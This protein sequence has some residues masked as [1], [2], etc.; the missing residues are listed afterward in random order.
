MTKSRS[1]LGGIVLLMILAVL[2]LAAPAGKASAAG[3]NGAYAN[4]IDNGNFEA[5]Y[6]SWGVNGTTPE[7]TEEDSGNHVGKVVG[8]GWV[9]ARIWNASFMYDQLYKISF[10]LKLVSDNEEAE[11]ST[12]QYV[13]RIKANDG[14]FLQDSYVDI[15]CNSEDGIALNVWQTFVYFLKVSDNRDGTYEVLAGRDPAAMAALGTG[16]GEL[17]YCDIAVGS[18][19]FGNLSEWYI[20]DYV[21]TPYTEYALNLVPNGDFE[22]DYDASAPGGWGFGVQ[23]ARVETEG[24]NHVGKIEV[25]GG[26]WTGP[27]IWN[28]AFMYGKTYRISFNMKLVAGNGAEVLSGGQFLAA[29]S[30]NDNAHIPDTTYID[31]GANAGS[32]IGKWQT[33]AYYIRIEKG[34]ERDVLYTGNTADSLTKKMDCL[35]T[36]L[37]HFNPYVGCGA[38]GNVTEVY[39]DD[40]QIVEADGNLVEN[41]GMTDVFVSEGQAT[42]WGVNSYASVS[43]GRYWDAEKNSYVVRNEGGG[44]LSARL[45]A[46]DI[47]FGKLYRMSAEIRMDSDSSAALPSNMHFQFKLSDQESAVYTADIGMSQGSLSTNAYHTAVAYFRLDR[48]DDGSI[49]LS[50]GRTKETVAPTSVTFA[51]GAAFSHIDCQIGPGHEG[52]W[53]IDNVAIFDVSPLKY[54]A[55]VV[56]FDA[57]E[58]PLT[59]FTYEISGAYE[60]AVL[61]D[62]VLRIIGAEDELSVSIRKEGFVGQTVS[63]TP[64]S[65]AQRLFLL[66]AEQSYTAVLTVL[67]R[68]GNPVTD[69]SFSIGGTGSYETASAEQNVITIEKVLGE[70]TVSLK[71]SLY[72]D[73]TVTV[74]ESTAAQ[75]VTFDRRQTVPDP[76]DYTGELYAYQSFEK[77]PVSDP[78]QLMD[79]FGLSTFI[80]GGSEASIAI[81]DQESHYGD[82]A[83]LVR[84]VGDRLV[85]RMSRVQGSTNFEL[86][87]T[88]HAEFWLK[89][90][91][92]GLQIRPC[93]YLTYFVEGDVLT[94][95]ALQSIDEL[96]QLGDAVTLSTDEWTKVEV[97]FSLSVTDGKLVISS[98]YFDETRIV[99]SSVAGKGIVDVGWFDLSLN[100]RG[101]YYLDDVTFFHTYTAQVEVFNADNE[102]VTDGVI[103]TAT[104]FAGQPL[105]L[106][107]EIREGKFIV[108]GAYGVVH[109]SAQV[110][111][112]V[113]SA[114][115][116]AANTSITMASPYT[117]TVAVLDGGGETV[118]A[119][120]IHDIY[121]TFGA[122]RVEGV[123]NDALRAYTF[124]G[125][126]G[127]LKVFVYAQGF[128][129]HEFLTLTRTEPQGE[130][131][132][133]KVPSAADGLRG[134][135]AIN[136]DVE[137]LSQLEM[138]NNREYAY[139]EVQS[140]GASDRWASFQPI[141]TLSEESAVGESSMRISADSAQLAADDADYAAFME[142]NGLSNRT[143]GDRVSY[144]AGNSYLL[145]GTTYCFTVYAKAPA[146]QAADTRFTLIFL[147]VV[148]LCN[149]GQFNFWVP[150]DV[151]VTN[152]YWSKIEIWFSFELSDDEAAVAAGQY[153]FTRSKLTSCV[154]ACL[155]GELLYDRIGIYDYNVYK[156]GTYAF[157]SPGTSGEMEGWGT[158]DTAGHDGIEGQEGGRS[159]GS[160]ALLEPSFQ[161]LSANSLLIDGGTI[162]SEYEG[163]ISVLNRDL[164]ANDSVAYLRLTDQYTGEVIYLDASAYYSQVNQKYYIPDLYHGY[165]VCVCDA[166]KNPI[167]DLSE[168]TISSEVPATVIEFD[169]DMVLTIKDQ[170]GDLVTDVIVRIL[171]ANGSY[172]QATNN[173]DGTYSYS[174]L[175]GVRQISFRKE[176]G[177]EN[178][179]TFPSGITVSSAQ[180][181]FEVVVTLR[182]EDPDPG[183]DPTPGHERRSCETFAGANGGLFAFAVL[184]VCGLAALKK[185]KD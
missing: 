100:A 107:P 8:A 56:V 117:A 70:I 105:N 118:S 86:D 153:E 146:T 125:C 12:A 129:Q 60:N 109:F 20:D 115:T 38:P 180:S 34:E 170:H 102:R 62:N 163:D 96:I 99:E 49:V 155:N 16:V 164:S 18:G 104:D 167:A 65:A 157:Y 116:S 40:Y 124:E 172:A 92:E 123:W 79:S 50:Y 91:T 85:F 121:A 90:I 174:G 184:S 55:E 150:V 24:G 178:S 35:G 73:V 173:G 132:L 69:F 81:T 46:N 112:L 71:K 78:V 176:S 51:D 110:G 28:A 72:T 177:S 108:E 3:K 80:N 7:R 32:A 138:Y 29:L 161:I 93:V 95:G 25:T 141:L 31:I 27:R 48:T 162:T 169:Y 182:S 89:G 37:S 103:L 101:D 133:K 36:D 42:N 152:D 139:P 130:F 127:D 47:E 66:S 1:V 166:D 131:R 134:N 53:Y 137:S 59:G 82:H 88:Y 136:G 14:A 145:D 185:K 142:A 111:D 64:T 21:M 114:A 68:E 122:T 98:P 39:L 30:S 74:S 181:R 26:F 135:T 22:L 154:R 156:D 106:T 11:T 83:M 113:Y 33:Y 58:A 17:S 19:N 160:I 87:K 6:V 128:E 44:W 63:I 126:M 10:N 149:G 9:Q 45:W 159:F 23:P 77:V 171:L 179:Y 147:A 119:E 97:E 54:E 41:G 61:E 15:G 4:L 94:S 168:Q 52:V 120:L 183:V 57:D 143:F 175:S 144:R 84:S 140:T 67:D 13:A 43:T 76:S 151:T 5:E 158:F 2:V 165:R 148:N 75:E